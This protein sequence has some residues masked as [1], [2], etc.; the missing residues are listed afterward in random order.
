MS[1][2][3]LDLMR[4]GTRYKWCMTP[5]CTT[6]GSLEYRNKLKNLA[7]PLGGGPLANA[8]DEIDIDELM[9]I[10]RWQDGLLIAVIDLPISMQVDGVLKA[11]LPKAT[12]NI[13]FADYVLFKI[14]KHLPRQS[15]TRRDWINACKTMAVDTKDFSLVESLILVLGQD[16]KNQ[17]ELLGIAAD[18][19]R[20]S[21]QMRRVLLNACNLNVNTA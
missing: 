11:W 5:Y 4:E 18:F 1:N 15:D 2:A 19:A 12:Q 9:R 8:L 16:A 6:C 17:P 21:S 7:G 13:R 20:T 10:P 3:L 14:T